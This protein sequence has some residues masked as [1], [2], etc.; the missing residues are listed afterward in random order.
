MYHKSGLA[1]I[2]S[3]YLDLKGPSY[4]IDTACSSSLHALNVGYKYIMSG[5][6]ED[7]IIG[8]A[9]LCLLSALN[10]HFARLGIIN[11]YTCIFI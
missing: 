10:L 7:A 9:N 6:C 11:I 5:K 8:A 2:I 1:N 3:Y 4:I